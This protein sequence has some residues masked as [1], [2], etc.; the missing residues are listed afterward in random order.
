MQDFAVPWTSN[1]KIFLGE[2]VPGFPPQRTKSLQNKNT[3]FSRSNF[4]SGPALSV[5]VDQLEVQ[6]GLL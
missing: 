1:F 6:Y 4:T 5:V 3:R 2:Y